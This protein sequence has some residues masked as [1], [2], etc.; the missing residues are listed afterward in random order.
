[1]CGTC[2]SCAAWS[3]IQQQ[4]VV[5]AA[6]YC[7]RVSA[8]L[9]MHVC[10]L[11]KLWSSAHDLNDAARSTFNSTSLLY[12]TVFYL[13]TQ[14]LVPPIQEL[15]ESDMLND[16]TRRPLCDPNKCVWGHQRRH[17]SEWLAR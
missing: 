17:V 2:T 10:R 4:A 7:W 6:G 11:V 8:A 13:Q 9:H 5:V 3:Y 16:T 12:L 1:M 15:V 14:Q